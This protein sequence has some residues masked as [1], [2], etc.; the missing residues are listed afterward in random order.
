MPA[1]TWA[2]PGDPEE[3]P[4]PLNDVS[5]FN[6]V[7]KFEHDQYAISGYEYDYLLSKLCYVFGPYLVGKCQILSPDVAAQWLVGSASP[8]HPYTQLYGPTKETVLKKLSPHDLMDHFS[9]CCQIFQSKLKDEL[10][11]KGKDARLFRI[12]SIAH[13]LKGVSLFGPMNCALMESRRTTPYALGLQCPGRESIDLWRECVSFSN[14]WLSGD[15]NQHDAHFPLVFA[16]LLCDFRKYYLPESCHSEIQRYYDQAYCGWTNVKG[17][18]VQINANP[19]GHFLTS[20]D[21][22][23]CTIMWVW[24]SMRRHHVA[25]TDVW[26]KA[27][28]DDIIMSTKDKTFT[29]LVLQQDAR[30]IGMRWSFVSDS[31]SEFSDLVFVG[32][33]PVLFGNVVK[34][35]GSSKLVDHLRWK[36]KNQSPVDFFS[37]ICSIASLLFYDPI[38]QQVQ[39][40]AILFYS[41]ERLSSSAVCR[42]LVNTIDKRFLDTLWNSYESSL[43]PTL[44]LEGERSKQI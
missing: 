32:T 24:L 40:F 7:N 13:T 26:F 20:S 3:V 19:S 8:G 5:L 2:W 31:F 18:L 22:T 42:S 15:G 36:L 6:G 14:N 25:D 4:A 37:K 44:P 30:S 16:E 17:H 39:D 41:S 1:G 33:H 9:S 35:S 28:G 21:N 29:R 23:L 27:V 38:F 11:P 12:G 43:L 10:R 34:C